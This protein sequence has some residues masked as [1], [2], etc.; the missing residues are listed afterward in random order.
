MSKLIDYLIYVSQVNDK[1]AM[2]KSLLE[3]NL[4]Y[5]LRGGTYGKKRPVG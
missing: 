5:T 1:T 4:R 2:E 3:L